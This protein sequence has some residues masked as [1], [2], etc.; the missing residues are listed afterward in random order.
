MTNE[1]VFFMSAVKDLE[2]SNDVPTSNVLHV[3]S[4]V[5]DEAAHLSKGF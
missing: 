3:I 2:E 4:F 1:L 5:R